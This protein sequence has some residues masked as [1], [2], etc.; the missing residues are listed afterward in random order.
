VTPRTFVTQQDV[1]D[2]RLAPRCHHH[3]IEVKNQGA[4]FLLLPKTR[5]ARLWLSDWP[6]TVVAPARVAD[7]VAG[8][9]EAG[10]VVR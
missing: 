9:R 1:E 7:V 4:T 10:L 5:R 8:A 6:T 2:D 3:D